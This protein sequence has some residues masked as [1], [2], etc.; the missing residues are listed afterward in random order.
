MMVGILIVSLLL[1]QE[2]VLGFR[3][4]GGKLLGMYI[5]VCQFMVVQVSG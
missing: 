2:V 5:Q 4:Q 1:Q 3:G